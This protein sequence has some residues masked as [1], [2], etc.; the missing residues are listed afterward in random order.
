MWSVSRVI[1]ASDN[2][3]FFDGRIEMMEEKITP[4]EFRDFLMNYVKG[5]MEKE[6][7]DK[8]DNLPALLKTITDLTALLRDA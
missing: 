3:C 6:E 7:P 2:R 8:L 1:K 4:E 5:A